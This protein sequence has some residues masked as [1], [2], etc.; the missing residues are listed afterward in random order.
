MAGEV[1]VRVWAPVGATLLLR[2]HGDGTSVPGRSACVSSRL[3][4][5]SGLSCA[6]DTGSAADYQVA[7]A[8]NSHRPLYAGLR[9]RVDSIVLHGPAL[10]T[11]I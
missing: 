2:L 3:K 10:T 4:G 5:D 8:P 11:A 1:A 9:Q 6:T 7:W